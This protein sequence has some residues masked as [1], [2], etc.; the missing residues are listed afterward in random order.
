MAEVEL[1]SAIR[2]GIERSEFLKR[3]AA[4]IVGGSTAVAMFFKSPTQAYASNCS[5]YGT[6]ST[7]GCFCA[8]TPTCSG[9]SNGNCAGSL[10]K[11]C[12]YWTTPNSEGNYCWC[13]LPCYQGSFQ[14]RYVCCDC[15]TGGSGGCSSGSGTCVCKTGYSV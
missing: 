2:R 10:R 1:A 14:V 12:T 15:W 4:V 8:S 11:R 13:S 6:V 9:C 3:S 7:W 5:V